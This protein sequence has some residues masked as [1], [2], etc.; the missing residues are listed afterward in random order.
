MDNE[1]I[2]V[3]KKEYQDLVDD[4]RFL[5]CLRVA[6]VD[7]WDWYDAAVQDYYRAYGDE[8]GGD[9]IG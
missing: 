9:K 7:N 2:I 5:E 6:G 3:N 1:T 8:K 4:S